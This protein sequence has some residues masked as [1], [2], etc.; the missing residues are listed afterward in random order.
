MFAKFSTL[1]VAVALATGVM[2]APA[3]KSNALGMFLSLSM[4]MAC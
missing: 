3:Y 2:S 1:F 4:E